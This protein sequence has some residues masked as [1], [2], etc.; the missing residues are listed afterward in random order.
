MKPE[1][2]QRQEVLSVPLASGGQRL[3]LFLVGALEGVSRKA[4]KQALDG[5]QVFVDGRVARKAAQP[6]LGG[7]TLRL[8]L[9][10]LPPRVAP[11]E[12]SLLLLDHD[13]LALNKPAGLPSHP[14]GSGQLDALSWACGWLRQQGDTGAPILLHRLDADTSGVLLL[15]RTADANRCLAGMFAQREMEKS[16]LA[17][18]AG[19]PPGEFSVDNYLRP[20]KR[21]RTQVVHSGGQRAQTRFRTLAQG[22][23]F[24][25][26]EAL[27]KTGRTHQIRVH[28]A[29]SGYALLGDLLYGGAATLPGTASG[30]VFRRHLLHARRLQFT[31]PRDGQ[32]VR[33]EAPIP[34]DFLPLL[35]LLP[36]CA[37]ES[38]RLNLPE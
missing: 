38:L 23:G 25:L 22:P 12:P 6:L 16:Y 7:E 20:G 26:V 32:R 35:G 14:T 4:I 18:V 3:D 36:D 13:L 5:G 1:L 15:A 27:P 10:G 37:A 9:S 8:T 30:L 28:L 24:A 21:G 33:I 17:L 34:A 19:T 31:H 11:A 2:V 29:E